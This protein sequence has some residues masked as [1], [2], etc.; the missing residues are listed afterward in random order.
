MIYFFSGAYPEA[1]ETLPAPEFN[2]EKIG[3][4]FGEVRGEFS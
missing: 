1:R 3:L 4:G 2:T